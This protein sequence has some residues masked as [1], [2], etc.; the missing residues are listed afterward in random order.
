MMASCLRVI[1][2]ALGLLVSSVAADPVRSSPASRNKE[3]VDGP[4]SSNKDHNSSLGRLRRGGEGAGEVT[5]PRVDEVADVFCFCDLPH[6]V[7]CRGNVR[8]DTVANLT[9][10]LVHQSSLLRNPATEE[11]EHVTGELDKLLV[12]SLVDLTLEGL[13]KLESGSFQGLP[14]LGLV[15]SSLGHLRAIAPGAFRGLEESLHALALPTNNL[16]AVPYEALQPLGLLERLDLSENHLEVL[17]SHAF[18][19]LLR[20]QHLDLSHN[21]LRQLQPEPFAKLPQLSTLNLAHNQLDKAQLNVRTFRGMHG[22]RELSLQANLL[23]GAVTSDLLRGTKQITLL[24]LSHNALTAVRRGALEDC[25]L[26]ERLDLS[27]NNIDVIEDHAFL[28]LTRLTDLRLETNHIVAVSG[29]SLGHLSRLRNLN[30][31]HNFLLAVT[32]DLLHQLPA[33]TSLDLADN[34]ISLVQ[35][36]VFNHTPALTSLNLA[37]NPLHCDCTLK[38]LWR[39]LTTSTRNMSTEDKSLAVCAT[40]PAIENAPLV[41]LKESALTCLDYYHDYYHDDAAVD[42]PTDLRLSSAKIQLETFRWLGSAEKG[43]D[44]DGEGPGVELTWRVDESALPYVCD[45]VFVYEMVEH[46]EQLYQQLSEKVYFNCSSESLPNPNRVVVMVPGDLLLPGGTYYY[47]LVIREKGT[48]DDESFIFECSEPLPLSVPPSATPPSWQHTRLNDTADAAATTQAYPT[49]TGADL[50]VM[51]AQ[52]AGAALVVHTRVLGG[53]ASCRYHVVVLQKENEDIWKVAARQQ[54]LNCSRS[55]LAF[56]DLRPATYTACATLRAPNPAL[57]DILTASSNGTRVLLESFPA[58]SAPVDLISTGLGPL[59]TLVF[60]LPGLV[61][62]VTLYIIV[63]R[64]WKGG[65]VLWRWDSHRRKPA[66]YF[67]YTGEDDTKSV[68]LEDLPEPPE[69]TTKV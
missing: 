53:E 17:P 44:S 24:D 5:C 22:L 26:L 51:T 67:L 57:Q 13:E 37:D 41:E 61:L 50:S 30:L 38:T 55:R 36:D 29:Y 32:A 19:A 48:S 21:G 42:E 58:C 11:A 18:P 6:T 15:V 28:H 34:D 31:A 10:T 46:Q 9:R 39:W 2:V 27:N 47:C 62:I 25:V 12:V 1:V 66:K 14:L 54:Q 49:T 8:R 60:T 23:K 45:A 40:P 69:T 4:S 43:T 3:N 65:G 64:V 52:Q 20:L 33:L 35:A 68:S 63:R 59:L 56:V 16:T 7:R